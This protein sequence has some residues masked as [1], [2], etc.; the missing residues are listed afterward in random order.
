MKRH[1][2]M[3]R[4]DNLKIAKDVGKAVGKAA[5][6]ESVKKSVEKFVEKFVEKSA[7][8][9]VQNPVKACV[10]EAVKDTVKKPAKGIALLS[11]LLILTLMSLLVAEFTFTFRSQ[12]R[13]VMTRQNLEQAYWYARSA[14]ALAMKGLSQAFR[15]GK[16]AVHLGQNWARQGLVLPVDG[17]QVSGQIRDAQGCFNLNALQQG[18]TADGGLP[19]S[20]RVFTRLLVLLGVEDYRAEQIARATRAWVTAPGNEQEDYGDDV[21]LSRPVPYLASRT[22]MR[23]AS[24][25]RAVAGVSQAIAVR[26]LPY[27]CAI[28]E[29]RLVINV[30]TIPVDQ[31]ALLAAFFQISG[32][33]N[34]PPEQAQKLLK[35]RPV[36]GWRSSAKFLEQPLL[37]NVN[38]RDAR[39]F[40]DI[41]S[42]YFELQA[43][44]GFAG[45]VTGL[46]SLLRRERDD[47][48]RVIRRKVGTRL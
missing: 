29:T 48:L 41:N 1:V 38:T 12:A 17:G 8:K 15:E 28:P 24:E 26:V 42:Y 3:P 9:S 10:R 23:D 20:L 30:N 13:R 45:A 27:L 19:E 31:P 7:E 11:I 32:Q 4:P 44:A 5:A 37:A 18:D 46:S 25:W 40:L 43:E 35:Q 33:D 34:L 36:N 14:E 47:R 2:Q 21:Y 6:K 16:G 22:L 39:P